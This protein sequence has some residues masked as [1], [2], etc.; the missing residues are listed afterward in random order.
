MPEPSKGESRKDFIS[1]CIPIIINEG[2]TDDS[3][4]AAAICYSIWRKSKGIKK[5]IDIIDL[6][7]LKKSID[8]LIIKIKSLYD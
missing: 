2:T 6:S 4:Q 3:K 5:S 7:I 1:R 8:N